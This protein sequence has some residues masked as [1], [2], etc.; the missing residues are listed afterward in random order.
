ML[1]KRELFDRIIEEILQS[2]I[3]YAKIIIES[4]INV[5]LFY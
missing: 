4:K 2:Y 1:H 5:N 3:Q